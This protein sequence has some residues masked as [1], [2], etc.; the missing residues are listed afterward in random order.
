MAAVHKTINQ[1][2]WNA[3][4]HPVAWWVWK[5]VRCVDKQPFIVCQMDAPTRRP[6]DGVK[7]KAAVE[8]EGEGEEEADGLPSWLARDNLVDVDK[9]AEEGEE[10]EEKKKES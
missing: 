2:T 6:L 1:P 3:S 5:D 10:E 4:I 7:G 9:M 8:G